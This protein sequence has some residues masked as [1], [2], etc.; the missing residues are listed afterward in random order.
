MPGILYAVINSGRAVSGDIDLRMN[1][2]AAIGVPVVTSGNLFLQ[3]G[4]DTTSANFLRIQTSASSGDMSYA[5]GPGSRMLI[6]DFSTPA[7]ARLEMSVNQTDIRTFQLW[8][9]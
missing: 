2:L 3:G 9:R 6:T 8:T 7:Y 1:A 5:T 4:F